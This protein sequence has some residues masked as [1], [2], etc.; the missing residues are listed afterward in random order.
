MSFCLSIFAQFFSRDLDGGYFLVKIDQTNIFFKETRFTNRYQGNSV[1]SIVF[2]SA[3]LIQKQLELFKSLSASWKNCF[4]TFF[5][6]Y[7]KRGFV[8]IS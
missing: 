7:I 4:I 8:Y 2:S 1:V 5:M 3:H 6:F